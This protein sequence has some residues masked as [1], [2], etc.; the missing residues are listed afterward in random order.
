MTT[1]DKRFTHDEVISFWTNP[2]DPVHK[3]KANEIPICE[4]EY[5]LSEET[6]AISD[7]LVELVKEFCPD[8]R[9][10][11]MELG[12]NVGRNLH[13]LYN[14]GYKD[15]N[16]IEIN[17]R[18]KELAQEH[19]PDIAD[20][21]TIMDIETYL[22]ETVNDVGHDLVFTASVLMHMHTDA[23]WIYG[24]IQRKAT[25]WIMTIE[26]EGRIPPSDPI[27]FPRDYVKIF[28]G[29]GWEHRYSAP[30]HATSPLVNVHIFEWS[31][32]D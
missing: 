16:G 21:I 31:G 11:I 2:N 25:R 13:W 27:R 30:F 12:C 8:R 7:G 18:C 5:F 26:R 14:A 4:P 1:H 10:S 32:N 23:N 17:P 19:F 6:H 22:A 20:K 9:I 28:S 29:N 3:I 15:V 24:A